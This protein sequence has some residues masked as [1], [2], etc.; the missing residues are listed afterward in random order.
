MK[1]LGIMEELVQYNSYSDEIPLTDG[2]RVWTEGYSCGWG[3]LYTSIETWTEKDIDAETET[4]AEDVTE[5]ETGTET[6]TQIENQNLILCTENWMIHTYVHS[7]I[8]QFGGTGRPHFNAYSHFISFI[9]FLR[10]KQTYARHTFLSSR[11]LTLE[12]LSRSGSI[13]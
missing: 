6:E 4:E 1:K 5:T 12:G 3:R 9:F 7:G 8:P 13:E 10:F 11:K 2:M